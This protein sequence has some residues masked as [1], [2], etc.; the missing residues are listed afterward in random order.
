[1]YTNGV[2]NT[3]TVDVTSTL[4]TE[5]H[6]AL[7]TDICLSSDFAMT[8]DSSQSMQIEVVFEEVDGLATA[9]SD[10]YSVATLTGDQG[11]VW[12]RGNWIL[13]ADK[14]KKPF[15]VSIYVGY[16]QSKDR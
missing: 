10:G 9:G 5:I 13:K 7:A 16:S 3:T 8:G 6:G 12:Y 1:M 15:R 14:T 11:D 2:G 4:A